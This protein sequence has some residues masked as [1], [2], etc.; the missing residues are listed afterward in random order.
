MLEQALA[1]ARET[2]ASARG[3]IEDLRVSSPSSTHF[4]EALQ[5]EVRRFTLLTGLPCAAECDLLSQ[6]PEGHVQQVL[7]VMREALAN[8]ARH[9]HA[10][11]AWVHVSRD[12]HSM[13]L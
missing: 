4:V 1:S 11:R 13:R 3:A 5:E 8:V 12:E 6:V 10:R 2:L 7:G 9:A